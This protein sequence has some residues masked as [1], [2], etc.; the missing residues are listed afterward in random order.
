MA[1]MVLSYLSDLNDDALAQLPKGAELKYSTAETLPEPT[2]SQVRAVFEKKYRDLDN[3]A[4]AQAYERL[5]WQNPDS[6]LEGR[7]LFNY[8]M[9]GAYDS[10]RRFYNEIRSNLQDPVGFSSGSGLELFTL[11]L[12][13]DDSE[14][15]RKV[16]E[17]STSGSKSDMLMHVWEAAMRDNP[18]EIESAAKEL[19]ERY[20]Q[21]QGVNSMGRRLL[22]FLP[23]LPAMKDPKHASRKEAIEFFGREDGWTILRFIWIEKYK[24]PVTDA[25]VFL[26]GRENSTFNQLLIAYLEKNREKA[27][28][29]LNALN[30]NQNSNNEYRV[31]GSCLYQKLHP[32]A[33]PYKDKDLKPPGAMTIRQA[34]FKSLEAQ[35]RLGQQK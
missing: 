16:L 30:S 24:I 4:R 14:L 5:Y 3:F 19:V 10:V 33:H 1:A 27:L 32:D 13:L 29:A 28:D 34:V 20:E 6:G 2:L 12:A 22:K 18:A 15:R 26:S 35:G 25:V 21:E 31:L 7:T 11:G 8:V 9:F 23:L 17:D